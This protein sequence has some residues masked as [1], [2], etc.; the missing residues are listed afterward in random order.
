MDDHR[1]K[2]R[3]LEEKLRDVRKGLFEAGLTQKFDEAAV[4]DKAME[5]AK[6]DAE[7]TVLRVKAFS[8]M[9]PPLSAEQMEKLK[10]LASAGGENR[11]E[12]ERSRPDVKRDENGLPLKK[13]PPAVKPPEN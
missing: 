3:G 6:L 5:A 4:R 1:D 13:Q 7:M 8:E 10:N 9:R 2:V 12:P 11:A